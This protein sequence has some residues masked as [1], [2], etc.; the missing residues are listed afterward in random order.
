[1]TATAQDT[2]SRHLLSKALDVHELTGP[3]R[4]VTSEAPLLAPPFSL[5]ISCLPECHPHNPA[6]LTSWRMGF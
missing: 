4:E 6:A 2:F 1:M 5:S 3:R